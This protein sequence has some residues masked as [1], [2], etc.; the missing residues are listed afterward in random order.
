MENRNIVDI[1]SISTEHPKTS[2]KLSKTI[3]QAKKVGSNSP[4]VLYIVIQESENF[5]NEK[6]IKITKQAH[7]FKGMQVFIILKF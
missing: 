7:A 1:K 5:L 4:I 3:R 6:D 2:Q